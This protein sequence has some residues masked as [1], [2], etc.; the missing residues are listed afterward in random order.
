MKKDEINKALLHLRKDKHISQL[1]KKFS[2]PKISKNKDYFGSLV[3]SIIY[4]QLSTKSAR[5][6]ELKFTASLE[7]K[8]DHESILKLKDSDFKKSGISPQKKRYLINLSTKSAEGAILNS[9]FNKMQDE[10]I[11][12]ALSKVKGIGVWTAQMFLIFTLARPNIFPLDDLG[13]Q[14]GVMYALG[15]NKLPSKNEMEKLSKKWHPHKTVASLYLW[16][17]ADSKKM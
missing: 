4:Q 14:K 8:I 15:K 7:G 12:S 2:V 3:R 9:N 16:K 10:E 6:I 11:I 5:S 17:L 13:I 1:I